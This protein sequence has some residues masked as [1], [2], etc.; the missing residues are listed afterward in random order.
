LGLTVVGEEQGQKLGRS[1]MTIYDFD[2]D[3]S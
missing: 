3:R 1:A 2:H